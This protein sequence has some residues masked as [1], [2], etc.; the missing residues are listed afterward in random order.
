[1]GKCGGEKRKKSS[2]HV[3]FNACDLRRHEKKKRSAFYKVNAV[4]I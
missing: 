1:M 4:L 2:F 3:D